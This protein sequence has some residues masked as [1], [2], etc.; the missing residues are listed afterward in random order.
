LFSLIHKE[1][2]AHTRGPRGR[3]AATLALA[4]VV[5]LWGV[6]GFEHRRAVAALEARTYQ[7]AEPLRASAYPTMIDPF[8]WFGVVE[9]RDFFVLAPVDSA[10]PEVGSEGQLEIYYKPEETP[11]TLAAKKS[12]WGRVFL[13]WAQYPITETEVLQ[14]PD[15][16]Y[17]VRFEDLRFMQLPSLFESVRRRGRH[18]RSGLG[19]AVQLDRNLDVVGD[20]FGSE[21]DQVVA[22]EPD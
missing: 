14:P 10:G 18:R 16:G 12:Y 5:L 4:G 22:P 11:V 9:T 6:R 3:A 8:R 15:Q 17:I 20:V 7:G 13:E 19:A 21:K 2:G 1:I